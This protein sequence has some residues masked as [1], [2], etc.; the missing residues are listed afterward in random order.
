MGKDFAAAEALAL[1]EMRLEEEQGQ[2]LELAGIQGSVPLPETVRV[3]Q[4]STVV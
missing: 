3:Q 2:G 4:S 1:W